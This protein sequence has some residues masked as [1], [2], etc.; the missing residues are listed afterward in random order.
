MLRSRS[1]SQGD[2]SRYKKQFSSPFPTFPMPGKLMVR[3]QSP[4]AQI[5]S[6][7]EFKKGCFRF[8]WSRVRPQPPPHRTLSLLTHT[9]LLLRSPVGNFVY[10]R[11]IR[12]CQVCA[13]SFVG[14]SHLT[15]IYHFLSAQA[16]SRIHLST[17]MGLK[18]PSPMIA[19]HLSREIAQ[20]NSLHATSG[21][22]SNP[23][24]RSLK[25]PDSRNSLDIL[26]RIVE[27]MNCVNWLWI[28]SITHRICE[29]IS[30]RISV[31]VTQFH[32]DI[33]HVIKAISTCR[34]PWRQCT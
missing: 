11:G 13:C 6:G 32:L 22:L 34:I 3:S 17:L 30:I 4:K 31:S 7:C 29:I 15:D 26:T 12:Q 10:R 9:P 2:S 14:I 20:G 27:P 28:I 19:K 33:K 25:S 21:G 16:G 18:R 8:V 5:S 24:K 1:D 23:G